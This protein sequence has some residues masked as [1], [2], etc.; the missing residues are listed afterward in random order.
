MGTGY[1]GP[2]RYLSIS[3]A[4]LFAF[5]IGV[6][7]P[8]TTI[9]LHEIV[10]GL[11]RIIRSRKIDVYVLAGLSTLLVTSFSTLFTLEVERIWIFLTPFIIIPA[12][13]RLYEK[14][15]QWEFYAVMGILCANIL[16]YEVLLYTYW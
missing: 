9:W 13:K 2:G 5:L 8:L 7:I 4:N 11:R 16:L 15:R 12:A 10:A 1:E 6:G 14:H 3:I